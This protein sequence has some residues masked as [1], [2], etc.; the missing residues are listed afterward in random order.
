MGQ[1]LA[2][3]ARGQARTARLR[4]KAWLLLT[5]P[6]GFTTWAAFL[7]IGIRARRVQWLVWAGVYAATLAVYVALDTPS[8]PG[9]TAEGVGA[10]LALLTW[11]GGGIH[12]LAISN[13]AVRRIQGSTDPV[14]EAARARMERRAEGRHLL[15]TQP[16]LAREVGVG[17]P[18]LAG[19]GD[20]GLIDVNHASAAT[21][22]KLPGMTDDLARRIV[23]VRTQTGGFSSVE[24]LGLLLDLQPTTV[25]QMRD[26][27]IAA[28][29]DLAGSGSTI[30][31]SVTRS[32]ACACI[33]SRLIDRFQELPPA[34]SAVAGPLRF[35]RGPCQP[36]RH[37]PGMD[38]Q[39]A[40]LRCGRR[41]RA[42]STQG[43]E[44]C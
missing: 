8:H 2:P 24:D 23:E 17:R 27:A 22:A 19:A 36:S 28:R 1:H 30:S 10:G 4:G 16:A 41:P 43:G 29:Q 26:M 14:V 42:A 13:D 12:A 35:A 40:A 7:Y 44:R 15:A 18:D 32:A 34:G 9:S 25:D 5:V 11:I 37:A 38:P 21:L 33:W 3:G 20:Y 39:A 6:L 31:I